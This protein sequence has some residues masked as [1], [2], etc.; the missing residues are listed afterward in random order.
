MRKLWVRSLA[1]SLGLLA[2][3]ARGQ[4]VGGQPP[5]P[6]GLGRPVVIAASRPAAA[7]AATPAAPATVAAVSIGRP[8]AIAPAA[9]VDPNLQPVSFSAPRDPLAPIVRGASPDALPGR[10]MPIGPNAD[11]ATAGM[12]AWRRSDEVVASTPTAAPMPAAPMPAAMPVA[13]SGPA[14]GGLPAPSG[15]IATVPAPGAQII[16]GPLAGTP[17]P[18]S[19]VPGPVIAGPG[20][21]FPGPTVVSGPGGIAAGGNCGCNS[22]GGGLLGGHGGHCGHA[23]GG[24]G[25]GCGGGC[26]PDAGRF[27]VGA[28]YLMWWMKGDNTPDLL[29]SAP[30]G[31]LDDVRP[32][33]PT[34]TV[35]YGGQGQ[36]KDGMSGLRLSGQYWF[37][38]DHCW[39]LDASVFYLGSNDIFFTSS[40]G[41]PTLVRPSNALNEQIANLRDLDSAGTSGNFLAE[42]SATLWG[43]DV[44]LRKNLW[45]GEVCYFDL[46]CGYRMVGL[47]EKLSITE[48]VL[49]TA[50]PRRGPDPAKP[51]GTFSV[52]NDQFVT[53]NRFFGPQVGFDSLLRK[54]NWTLGIRSK[55]AL[56][57]TDQ[58]VT[59]SG[60]TTTNGQSAPGGFL[61]LQGTNIGRETHRAFGVVPEV[62]VTVGY[63]VK[64]W[65][66]IF[67]GYNFLYWNSVVR[68]GDQ[69]NLRVNPNFLPGGDRT[70]AAEP[71][72]LFQRS[73]FWAHGVSLGME[74]RW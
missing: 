55:V 1:L 68:P 17:M 53:S 2:T 8:V 29:K 30:S 9:R 48:N 70:G 4:D 71:S 19:P 58:V 73:E 26:C 56:G 52:V 15:P 25:H 66:R 74:F 57:V 72:P 50:D 22:C 16:S 47:E 37:S 18:G 13:P 10:P 6:V 3:S 46:I 40:P 45:C 14:L 20:G 67:A 36:G 63:D 62:G 54:G 39:G 69:I 59:I 38:D 43:F 51:Y 49:I 5:P 35:L 11:P 44:N 12:H 34:A 33:S 65:W 24:C 27:V 23:D 42:R 61:A 7:P 64:D 31:S 60:S 21:P 28:E 41:I 32:G